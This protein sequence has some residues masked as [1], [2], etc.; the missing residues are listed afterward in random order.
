MIVS[1]VSRGSPEPNIEKSTIIWSRMF[2]WATLIALLVLVGVPLLFILLQAIFPHLGQG[3]LAEP[4]SAMLPVFSDPRLIH[5]TLNTLLLGACVSL[6]AATVGAGLGA[7]RA[8][9][10]IPFS[11]VWDVIL[12][13]P[14]MIPPYIATFGWIVVLQPRGYL[15][16]VA[17]FH[18]G[19]F[20]FSFPGL[21]FI[22][23]SHL[24]P[25]VYFAVSRSID[26]S[27]GQ[28]AEAA[29]MMGA[30]GFDVFRRITL[31]LALPAIG[32]ALLLV[33]AATIEEFGT[34]AVL[35]AQSGF[36]VL[37]TA[38][39]HRVSDWPIDLPGA[40]S[41]SIILVVLALTAFLGQR[42][43][44]AGH[45]YETIGGKP[46][47]RAGKARRTTA[48]MGVAALALAALATIGLPMFGILSTALTRTFSGGLSQSNLSLRNFELL[49]S[50]AGGALEAMSLSVGLAIGTALLTA[51]VG[52]G[53]A[54]LGHYR[55]AGD[56]DVLG[57]LT[58]L[59]NAVPGI[60]VAVGLILA[61]NQPWLPAS[62]YGTSA[63]LLLAYSCILLPYPVRYV[64]AAMT[65]ITPDLE[66]A[67]M[68]AG[69]TR[70]TV[71]RRIVL[72]LIWPSLIAAMMLVFAIASRE[73]VASILLAPVGS[74]TM[75]TYV[76]KQFE[77]GSLGLGM[78]MSVVAIAVTTTI[79][80]VVSVMS[81]KAT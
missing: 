53:A 17:G 30:S 47:A 23:A 42:R 14:F 44:I 39:D 77:Q 15:Q 12:L 55:R 51:V 61:W 78:A 45:S 28:L 71:F 8:I 34:P 2:R 65:Q 43:L 56:R 37:T 27:S 38:I 7:I 29:R 72:P 19:P 60:V 64:S 66:S 81:R 63:M 49:F 35:G 46:Q 57:W 68:L 79:M 4:L 74:H 31:P 3:S 33:F 58:A 80:L 6:A 18:L 13:T 52:V 10:P 76:W 70:F 50:N 69:A 75:A 20:L 40:A 32:G 24:F 41:L 67:A 54:L 1:P 26:A 21:V 59:P 5:L 73:L 16:Q 36:E 48:W 25:A 9:V 11:G 62:I 22:M